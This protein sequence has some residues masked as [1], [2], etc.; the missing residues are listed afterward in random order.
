LPQVLPA[1]VG[2]LLYTFDINIRASAILGIV[3]GGGIGFLLF[4]SMKVLAFETTGAIILATFLLVYLI[5]ILAG[6]VRRQII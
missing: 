4:N 3:G 6:Y 2:Q 5:E 1:L